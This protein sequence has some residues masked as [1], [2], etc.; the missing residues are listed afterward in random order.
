MD[1]IRTMLARV[2]SPGF[3][4][5][6]FPGLLHL[7]IGKTLVDLDGNVVSRGYSWRECANM[8]K[9]AR[10]D[11]ELARTLDLNP[12]DLPP[13]DREK[14]WYVALTRF[15]V[16]SEKAKTCAAALVPWMAKAGI[17]VA[18]GS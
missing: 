7:L 17:K 8:L 16:A 3:P 11:P 15:P 14:F 1:A 18:Q 2:R 4:N 9:T 13:R 6:H 10:I 5:D 12:D